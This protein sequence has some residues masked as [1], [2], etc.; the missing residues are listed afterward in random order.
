MKK[1]KNL[2]KTAINKFIDLVRFNLT[3]FVESFHQLHLTKEKSDNIFI[4]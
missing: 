4:R 3:Y 2:E 1:V